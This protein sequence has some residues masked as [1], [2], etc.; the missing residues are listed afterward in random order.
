MG[1]HFK[2]RLR[3]PDSRLLGMFVKFPTTE[4]SEILAGFKW[5]AVAADTGL[6]TTAQAAPGDGAQVAS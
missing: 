6:F 4:T 1:S 2:E 3:A 5:L